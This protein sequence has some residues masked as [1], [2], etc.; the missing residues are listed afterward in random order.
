MFISKRTNQARPLLYLENSTASRRE[1]YRI[2]GQCAMTGARPQMKWR[3]A[4][5]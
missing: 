1:L 3:T 2:C 4:P 5:A